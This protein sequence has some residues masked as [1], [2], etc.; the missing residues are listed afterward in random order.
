M[1]FSGWFIVIE[2]II[3]GLVWQIPSGEAVSKKYQNVCKPAT[4]E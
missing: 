2:C 3:A 4:A 1:G